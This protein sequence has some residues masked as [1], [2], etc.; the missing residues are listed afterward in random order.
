MTGLRLGRYDLNRHA[1]H[2]YVACK[3]Q[4]ARNLL[5][6]QMMFSTV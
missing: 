6:V 5:N 2:K 3:I 4:N 1:K